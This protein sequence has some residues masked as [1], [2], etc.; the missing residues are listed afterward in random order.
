MASRADQMNQ[1]STTI[2]SVGGGTLSTSL[3]LE[4]WQSLGLMLVP[5]GTAMIAGSVSMFVSVDNVNFY[6]LKDANNATISIPHGTTAV[7][8]SAA[9]L[10]VIQPYR[11]VKWLDTSA[12]PTGMRITVPTKLL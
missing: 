8:Y 1:L 11:Y 2:G 12:Q 10:A 6:A 9:T 3:D 7:A 4:G 5:A